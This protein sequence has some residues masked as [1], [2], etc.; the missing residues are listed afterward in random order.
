MSNLEDIQKL[1]NNRNI[2]Q[3][4]GTYQRFSQSNLPE[5]YNMNLDRFTDQD[6]SKTY[7]IKFN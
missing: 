3:F 6:P 1:R 7:S 5:T 4:Y 2:P